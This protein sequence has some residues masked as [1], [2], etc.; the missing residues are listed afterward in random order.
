MHLFSCV[1]TKSL[2]SMLLIKL[3][4]EF[5][6]STMFMPSSLCMITTTTTTTKSFVP[7]IWGRLHEPKENYA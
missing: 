7:S 4:T 5:N 1:D 6:T 2:D 3:G